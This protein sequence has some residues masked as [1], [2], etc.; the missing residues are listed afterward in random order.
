M[1]KQG[2]HLQ[3]VSLVFTSSLLALA[4]AKKFELVYGNKRVYRGLQ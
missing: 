4:Q 2:V 3:A 1:P